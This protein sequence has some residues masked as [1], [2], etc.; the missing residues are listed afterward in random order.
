[1]KKPISILLCLV[2]LFS[3]LPRCFAGNEDEFVFRDGITWGMSVA[4]VKE[5]EKPRIAEELNTE[6]SNYTYIGYEGVPV[7]SYPNANLFYMFKNGMLYGAIYSLDNAS[8][9]TVDYILDALSSKY[10]VPGK[11]GYTEVVKIMLY[12]YDLA[13]QTASA[14][15]WEWFDPNNVDESLGVTEATKG[16]VRLPGSSWEL[17]DGTYIVYP[18]KSLSGIP[19]L[20]YFS[21]EKDQYNTSGL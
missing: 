16:T 10:G 4:E 17:P 5:H 11:L 19:L 2:I 20:L 6:G 8:D 9:Q 15:S 18:D 7:S 12:L 3:V 13:V 14:D 21:P 1:M